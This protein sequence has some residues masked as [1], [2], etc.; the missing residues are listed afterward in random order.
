VVKLTRIYKRYNKGGFSST[1]VG[2]KNVY[3]VKMHGD[4]NVTIEKFRNKPL[5][6]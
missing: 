4:S 6:G 5:D 2:V 3:L 1:S